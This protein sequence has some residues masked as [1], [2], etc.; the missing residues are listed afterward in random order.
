MKRRQ[1]TPAAATGPRTAEGKA[2][3]SQ[4]SRVHGLSGSHIVLPHE[5]AA[6]FELLHTSLT[7]S[8]NPRNE[9]ERA[10]VRHAAES[11]WL[12]RRAYRLQT[13]LMTL[14][15]QGED[16]RPTTPDERIAA[17]MLSKSGDAL[18]K[19]QRYA[20]AA[21][22]SYYRATKEL[23]AMADRFE[24]QQDPEPEFVSQPVGQV[25][26]LRP[27]G[28]RPPSE[29]DNHPCPSSSLTAL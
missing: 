16:A 27:V 26:N 22:R 6:Q 17:Y 29:F 11:Q 21:E 3:S 2:I 8:F 12:M 18:A 23:C 5:N 10:L 25:V 20:A 24:I 13:A 7:R 14:I 1:S 9:V 19:V 28:N 4:N 15:A